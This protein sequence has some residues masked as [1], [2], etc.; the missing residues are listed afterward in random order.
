MTKRGWWWR[1]LTLQKWLNLHKRCYKRPCKVLQVN[2]ML[3]FV[4]NETEVFFEMDLAQ[5][6]GPLLC[7]KLVLHLRQHILHSPNLFLLLLQQQ[8]G[9]GNVVAFAQ[10]VLHQNRIPFQF[11]ATRIKW[12]RWI[13]WI[14]FSLYLRSLCGCWAAAALVSLVMQAER[15]AS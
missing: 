10:I 6:F 4:I 5:R 14:R 3:G 15:N 2:F 13:N 8:I 11:A 1:W 12:L 7:L 9:S